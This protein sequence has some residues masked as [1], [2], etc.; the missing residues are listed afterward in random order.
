MNSLTGEFLMSEYYGTKNLYHKSIEIMNALSTKFPDMSD[1][2]KYTFDKLKIHYTVINNMK[3]GGRNISTLN[4]EDINILTSLAAIEDN[5]TA[6]LRAKLMLE[7][8]ESSK[9]SNMPEPTSSANTIQASLFPNPS[10]IACT[11]QCNV[12]DNYE[13]P[14]IIIYDFLGNTIYSSALTIGNNTKEINTQNWYIGNYI[15]AITNGTQV[16]NRQNL[17]ISR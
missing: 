17:L 16:L 7:E 15:V 5:I 4:A 8:Y 11:I 1:E 9:N 13:N 12:P 2:E 10:N 14:S 3:L 6:K